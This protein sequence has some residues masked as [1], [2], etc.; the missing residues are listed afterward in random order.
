[1]E[2]KATSNEQAS[3]GFGYVL[4]EY[5][6]DYI[7][8]RLCTILESFGMK[9][10]QEKAAKDIV[11]QEVDAVF[12]GPDSLFIPGGLNTAIQNV[13]ARIQQQRATNDAP[14]PGASMDFQ[15]EII[16]TEK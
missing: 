16:A 13:V 5:K 2:I 10:T 7:M 11:R 4:H 14:A 1:M 3:Y 15:F 9:D 6:R 12:Y 8:G